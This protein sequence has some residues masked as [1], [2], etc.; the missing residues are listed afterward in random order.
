MK[1]LFD[2]KPLCLRA[3]SGRRRDAGRS[4]LGAVLSAGCLSFIGGL[5]MPSGAD[6]AATAAAANS[7]TTA[8]SANTANPATAAA[9]QA[10]AATAKSAT[11]AGAESAPPA[12][13]TAR[14]ESNGRRE[15]TPSVPEFSAEAKAW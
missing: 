6:A 7:A 1:A 3:G 5:L 2:H 9:P 14:S 11:A 13:P 4:A 10:P 15:P 12:A 8:T